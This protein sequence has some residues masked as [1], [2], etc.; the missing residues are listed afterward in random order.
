MHACMFDLRQSA[1]V[2]IVYPA[3]GDQYLLRERLQ[4]RAFQNDEAC[5][6]TSIDCANYTCSPRYM[7]LSLEDALAADIAAGCA[8]VKLRVQ[9]LVKTPPL[10]CDYQR[11]PITTTHLYICCRRETVRSVRPLDEPGLSINARVW[12][13]VLTVEQ[14]HETDVQRV[15]RA[16]CAS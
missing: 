13:M 6:R 12:V 8:A 4:G 10:E 16:E 9:R 1:L 5:C 11:R 2:A 7:P 14:R 15:K 3:R